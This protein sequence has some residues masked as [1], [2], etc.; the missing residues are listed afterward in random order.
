MEDYNSGADLYTPWSNLL[1]PRDSK[2][3]FFY[4]S[5]SL[6]YTCNFFASTEVADSMSGFVWMVFIEHNVSFLQLPRVS[7]I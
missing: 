3:S 4:F 2:D 5:Y 7:P 6:T 1:L